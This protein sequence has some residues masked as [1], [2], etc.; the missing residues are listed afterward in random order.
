MDSDRFGALADFLCNCLFNHDRSSLVNEKFWGI[1]TQHTQFP[2]ITIFV[3]SM[4]V[5]QRMTKYPIWRCSPR[6]KRID[7]LVFEL[8]ISISFNIVSS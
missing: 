4:T 5:A 8:D 1:H 2:R 6:L 7:D 3:A